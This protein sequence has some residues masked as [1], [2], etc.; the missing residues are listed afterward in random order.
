MV[1][2]LVGVNVLTGNSMGPY[3]KPVFRGRISQN[4][5]D[6]LIQDDMNGSVKPA[7]GSRSVIPGVL[8]VTI[9]P[10]VSGIRKDRGSL[11]GP[12]NANGIF[13]FKRGVPY[14]QRAF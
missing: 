9:F 11:A 12:D 1:A 14:G 2:P 13:V 5:L 8:F 7:S 10:L 6:F 4:P 3:H